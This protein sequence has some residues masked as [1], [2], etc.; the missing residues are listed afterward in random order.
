MN[1]NRDITL[2]LAITLSVTL[3]TEAVAQQNDAVVKPAPSAASQ[4]G[5]GNDVAETVVIES[6]IT[7]NQE[8]PKTI[9][10]LP[11]Q[12]SVARIKMPAAERP[13]TDN[14]TKPLDREQFLRFI[15]AQPLLAPTN[16]SGPVPGATNAA[17]QQPEN[18]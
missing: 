4:N 5:K 9:Y 10:V 15:Q 6:T 7:G 1:T 12:D 14:A 18:Q 11:W 16:Q 8:Q 3:A 13:K 2:L 17:E